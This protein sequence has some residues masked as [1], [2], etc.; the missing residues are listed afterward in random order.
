VGR[1]LDRQVELLFLAYERQDP[2]ALWLLRGTGR[3]KGTDEELWAAGLTVELARAAI[4][5]DHS[6][7][8]WA[9]ARR[10][11]DEPVDP[12]FEAAC[13]AIQWGDIPTLTLL[14]DETPDLVHQRSP[15]PH[16]AM[17]LHHVAANGIEVERQIQ[18]PGNAVEV[19]HLLLER[20]AS[21]DADCTIYGDGQTTMCLLVSSAHPAKAG[22]QAPLVEE[23]CRGGANPNGPADDGLPLRTAISFGYTDAAEALVRGGARTDNLGFAAALGDLEA[24]RSLIDSSRDQLDLALIWAAGHDRRAVVDFLITQGPDLTARDPVFGATAEGYARHVGNVE[25]ADVLAQAALA[26]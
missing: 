13:D 19:M 22:V 12:R 24:V 18:S 8:S 10:H 5:R 26:N 2:V 23:L 15:F 4:A 6:Y 25:V 17:L 21:A 11:A 16:R 7:Q 1:W 14:L 9:D 3:A 20:G